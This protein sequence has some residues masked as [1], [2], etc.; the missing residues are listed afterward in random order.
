MISTEPETGVRRRKTIS[1]VEGTRRRPSSTSVDPSFSPFY[2]EKS[3]EKRRSGTS[4][5]VLSHTPSKVGRTGSFYVL[6]VSFPW[7]SGL[8]RCPDQ[9][10]R[11]YPITF[12]LNL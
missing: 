9:T 4:G 12:N 10:N 3:E 1:A 6:E 5:P 8:H 7:K 2:R 11:K